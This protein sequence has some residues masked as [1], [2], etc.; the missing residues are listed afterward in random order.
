VTRS[1]TPDEELVGIAVD[2]RQPGGALV[3]RV[4]EAS[5]GATALVGRRVLAGPSD[6]C[7]QCEVCRSGGAAVC[8][9]PRPRPASPAPL[10]RLPTRWLV[11]LADGLD[12]PLPA[13][14]AVA[15]DVTTAYTLYA[16]TGL[17]PRDPAVITGAT[18]VTRFLVDILRAKGL[19]PTV[20]VAPA[21]SGSAPP[22]SPGWIDWLEARGARVVTSAEPAAVTAAIAAQGLGTRPSRVLCTEPATLAQ[23][24]ALAG[25][26]ATLTVLASGDAPLP[27]SLLARE[28]LVIG[29][30]GPHPDLVVEVA[31]LCAKGDLDL[32]GGVSTDP[33]DRTRATVVPAA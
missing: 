19:T 13:A 6:P 16:R 7:G 21:G 17:G 28:V 23:A 24:A 30:A 25:P 4:E 5:D 10:L 22:A 9:H 29:V 14:A 33:T 32:V 27:A 11:P 26:R 15:G 31:A 8:P 20:V 18:G 1:A 3:G 2:A 12:L